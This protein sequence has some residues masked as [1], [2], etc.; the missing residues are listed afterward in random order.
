MK[1]MIGYP[2][3]PS[4]K[5][6]P[7]LS[8]NRQFQ[9][10]NKPTYVYPMVPAYAATL[11]ALDGH[12]VKWADGIAEGW[13]PERF[14]HEYLNFDPDVVLIE[15]KTPIIK[16]YWSVI[17]RLKS[18]DPKPKIILCGDHVTAMPDESMAACPVDYIIT[19]GN[20]DFQLR[21]LLRHLE[22]RGNLKPGLWF[23]EGDRVAN[24]GRFI[25]DD[26]LNTLPFIDRDLTKWNLYA[27]ENGNFRYTP[28]TYTMAGRDCWWGKCAF[29][30]W[31]TLYNRWR[32]VTPERLADEVGML[33]DKY[34]VKEI[35]D[36]SGCFPAGHWLRRFC[37]LVVERGYHKKV[38]LGCNMIPGALT[39]EHYDLMAQ[40]NFRFLL[41]G[42]E[43]AS[44]ETLKRIK[45]CGKAGDIE[46][47]MRM[48]KQSGLQPHVTCMVGYPWETEAQ[49][50]DTINLTRSL[51]DK[52]YIDTLQATVVIPYPGTPLFKECRDQGW[53]KT[54]DWD[55]YDMREP[56]MKTEMPDETV[57][58]LTREIY[59]SFL[60][61]RFIW[62]K[63]I[64]IRSFD[65]I[66]FYWRAGLRVVGHLLDFGKKKSNT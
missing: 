47:S 5:G 66:R 33:I 1:V 63:L 60:T 25:L 3:L 34:G 41:F 45:K 17:A 65:D 46:N 16:A 57:M 44:P 4:E 35:F 18:L 19:G 56:I 14:E 11:A 29:C 55:R 20:Y 15:C 31:T 62:R 21:D 40:A 7:L 30:S 54:E 36:D 23:R 2:P 28:G 13:Y 53:L 39:Q 42:L 48:A 27:T 6:V 37:E 51:F 49:A 64:S 61:P 58:A 22:K 9:W 43:S 26:D 38:V 12:E 59:K 8:Q 10:F 52:G 24:T 50:R 32:C